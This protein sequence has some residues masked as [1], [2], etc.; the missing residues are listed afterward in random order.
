MTDKITALYCRLSQ[1]DM[2]AGESNSITN[3]KDILS[4]YASENGF[5]NTAFYVDDGFSGTNFDRP[6]FQRM[7]ADIEEGRIGT[8]IV[9][10]LSRLGREYLQTG[11][12]TEM[13]FPQ[14]DV[15]FIAIHDSVDTSVGDNEFAP[16]K[17]IMNEFYAK[18]CSKKIRA[19]LKAKGQSGKPVGVRPPYGYKKSE[20]DKNVWVIDDPAA[21]VVR[22]IFQLCIEGHG[23]Y[24][25]AKILTADGIPTP[26]TYALESGNIVGTGS[27]KHSTHWIGQ[28][29][30]RILERPEYAGHTANFKTFKKSY[31]CK[32]QIV[33]PKSEWLIFE[34]THE[35]IISQHD[36]DLVQ[37]LRANKRVPQKC[38]I[39]NPLSGMVYCADCGA[40]LYLSRASSIPEQK[41]SLKCGTYS[42][43]YHECTAHYIRSSI[44]KEIV[45]AEIN[46][47]LTNVHTNEDTFIRTTM[48]QSAASHLDEVKKAKRTLT[49]FEQR[50]AELDRLFAKLYEDNA[51]GKISDERFGQL[52]KSYEDE[53]HKLKADTVQLR[54]L[55]DEREQK[56][57]DINRFISLVRKYEHIDEL[58]PEIMHELVEK[59][60]VHERDKSKGY[61]EQE[62]DI[63]FRFNIAVVSVL[64]D[65]REYINNKKAA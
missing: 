30:T 65:S 57:S 40:K 7:K 60:V 27:A 17:N 31:K 33:K 37:Q 29:V 13:Y 20:D 10:D 50:I 54:A 18:D 43:H 42:K 28:E 12:Y 49:R 64:L 9:K 41:E 35:P 5:T 2:L 38:E 19:V 8:V 21:S 3:Q 56:S 15:R 52:S 32:K 24:Q 4:K 6:D 55:I 51:L 14:H 39:P 47:V 1:D 23:P 48:E 62:V 53:Q 36:Y 26:S 46:K 44:L 11:Y 58:T 63:Y 34:N 45:V 16:F 22:R 59:I 25:I 61:R